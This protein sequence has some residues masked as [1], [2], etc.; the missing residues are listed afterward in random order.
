[1]FAHIHWKKHMEPVV[2]I[3]DVQ[4]VSW[5][6]QF[7]QRVNAD[8]S[9]QL[10]LTNKPYGNTGTEKGLESSIELTK[11]PTTFATSEGGSDL[12]KRGLKMYMY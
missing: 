6:H 9:I 5:F 1:M 10:G 2:G 4:E 8:S 12:A 3:V 7:H 11:A